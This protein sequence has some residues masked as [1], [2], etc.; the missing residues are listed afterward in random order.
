MSLL[1]VLIQPTRALIMVDTLAAAPA[2]GT[3][4]ETSKIHLLPFEN[5]VICSRGELSFA[6]RLYVQLI[7]TMGTHAYDTLAETL[8]VM[9]NDLLPKY[10][11]QCQADGIKAEHTDQQEIVLVGWSQ[12]S[13]SP[14]GIRMFRSG[15]GFSI[16]D[17]GDGGHIAPEPLEDLSSTTVSN[18]EEWLRQVAKSQMRQIKAA[19]GSGPVGGH[20]LLTELTQHQVTIKRMAA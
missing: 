13:N 7:A 2:C 11:A 8:P 9:A 3:E 19:P 4:F 1:N 18:H 6:R 12:R 17:L 16:E 20:L 15:D 14:R 10:L 5:V